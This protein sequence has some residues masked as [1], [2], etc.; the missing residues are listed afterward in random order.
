M[1]KSARSR[2]P[3][4]A[5]RKQPVAFG[6]GWSPDPEERKKNALT[7]D[8]PEV[9]S[10]LCKGVCKD[11]EEEECEHHRTSA[12]GSRGNG[13]DVDLSA[14]CSAV[15]DQGTSK[16]CSACA[17]VGLF[18]YHQRKHFGN[19]IDLSV[20]FLHKVA[21]EKE[22]K[23]TDT[24]TYLSTSMECMM[25]TGVVPEK[26]WPWLGPRLSVLNEVPPDPLRRTARQ[27]RSHLQYRLERGGRKDKILDDLRKHIRHQHPVAFGFFMD[28]SVYDAMDKCKDGVFPAPGREKKVG[29]SVLAV[30]YHNSKRLIKVRNSWGPT[31]GKGGY[32]YLPYAYIENGGLSDDFWSI[33]HAEFLRS[34]L[35]RKA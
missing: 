9:C 31:W 14:D 20:R 11:Y 32:G 23:S 4:G 22:E 24:G 17:T 7:L 8:S 21:R 19:H 26:D 5:R 10:A 35:V 1:A 3:V 13:M 18:E 12:S 28:V 6:T 30:G 33:T 27:F 2:G 25:D 34:P 29:H 16:A 15:E